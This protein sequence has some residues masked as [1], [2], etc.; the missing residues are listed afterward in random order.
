[1]PT[2]DTSTLSIREIGTAVKE[3]VTVLF[4]AVIMAVQIVPFTVSHPVHPLKVESVAATGVSTAAYGAAY[5]PWQSP[6][7]SMPGP[8]TVPL[9][10]P[11]LFTVRVRRRQYPAKKDPLTVLFPLMTT[12]QS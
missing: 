10:E 5:V 11:V 2:P 4:A 1:V 12:V 7:Q 6:P 3:A 9:P 8:V